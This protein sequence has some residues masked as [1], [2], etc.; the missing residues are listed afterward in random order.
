MVPLRLKGSFGD[1]L[2]GCNKGFL[3]SQGSCKGFLSMFCRRCFR[4]PGKL[5]IIGVSY[6]VLGLRAWVQGIP[7]LVGQV[8]ASCFPWLLG[9]SVSGLFGHSTS[10]S[11]LVLYGLLA[12]WFPWLLGFSASRLVG[13]S[14]SYSFVYYIIRCYIKL[15]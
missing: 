15:Y 12:S 9:F 13:L 7:R 5:L 3:R 1:S 10:Y 2:Q 8:L 11:F 6:G 14:T 4:A